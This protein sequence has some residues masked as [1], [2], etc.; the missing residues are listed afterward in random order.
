MVFGFGF[1]YKENL[2]GVFKVGFIL[3]CGVYSKNIILK[4]LE[5]FRDKC[6]LCWWFEGFVLECLGYL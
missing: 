5:I 3:F 6:D 1:D 4:F 2:Y